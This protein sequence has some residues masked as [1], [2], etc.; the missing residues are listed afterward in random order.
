MSYQLDSLPII[1]RVIAQIMPEYRFKTPLTE[2][3][4]RKLRIGDSVLLDGIIFG[5][6][7]GNLIRIFDKNVAPPCDWKGAAL[8]E[9]SGDDHPQRG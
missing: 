1:F 8:L 2:A 7:D 3:D 5:V 6:R 9:K 4:V